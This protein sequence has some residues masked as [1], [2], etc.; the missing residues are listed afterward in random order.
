MASPAYSTLLTVPDQTAEY[1]NLRVKLSPLHLQ[2]SPPVN[3][4]L[5][6]KLFYTEGS[7]LRK[8]TPVS[9]QQTAPSHRFSVGTCTLT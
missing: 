7:P 9:A 1:R 6:W 2:T 4:V 8:T 3:K 5:L